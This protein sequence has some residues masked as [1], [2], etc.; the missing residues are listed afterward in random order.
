VRWRRLRTE[1][2]GV[3]VGD[4]WCEEPSIVR[5]EAKNLFEARFRATKDLGVR[6]DEVEFKSLS[7]ID[8]EGL[9]AVFSEK[10]IRD[11]VWQCEGSKSPEPD[12]F[13]FNFIKK[14][15][16]FLKDDIM[17]ALT[18]FHET[19]SISKGCN[20]SFIALV[21][22]VRDPSKL[23]QYRPISLVGALYKIISKVLAIRMNKVLPALMDEC[24]SAFVK[25]RG[26]LDSVL[27]ENE[28][29]EDLRRNEVMCLKVD[30]EKAYD[31]VRWEFLYDMLS[32][33]GFHNL[34]IAWIKECLESASVCVSQREPYGGA[35]ANKRVEAGRLPNT[36]SVPSCS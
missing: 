28:V 30:F 12:G 11:A 10:E 1:V 13:N 26:I 4:Q 17:A 14:S 16:E 2:K 3:Q 7:P 21:P 35:Q 18:L 25:G 32:R 19:G 23:E 8:N 33:M 6:L 15:W 9:L 31:S 20:A 5:L 36:L 29:V 34:W 24:Q 22:I 27:M